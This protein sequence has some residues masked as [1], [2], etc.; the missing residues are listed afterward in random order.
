[1][2]KDEKLLV[3]AY[4]T[5]TEKAEH[6]NYAVDGCECGECIECSEHKASKT[7]NLTSNSKIDSEHYLK[8]KDSAVK[9]KKKIKESFEPSQHLTRFEGAYNDVLEWFD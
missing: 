8:D 3:E 4:I 6:C 2:H 7:K 9:N 1:M 5:M